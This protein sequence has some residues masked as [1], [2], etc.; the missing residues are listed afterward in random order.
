[1]ST[2]LVYNEKIHVI[3]A[4]FGRKTQMTFAKDTILTNSGEIIKIGAFFSD[5]THDL[6]RF[7]ETIIS[8]ALGSMESRLV[9]LTIQELP[10]N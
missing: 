6:P 3:D 10:T 9:Y 7:K 4:S 5:Q 1:M 2:S 8:E